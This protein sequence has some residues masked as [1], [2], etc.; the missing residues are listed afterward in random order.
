MSKKYG[1]PGDSKVPTIAGMKQVC[2]LKKGDILFSANSY[3]PIGVKSVEDIGM[4]DVYQVTTDDGRQFVCSAD[5]PIPAGIKTI[6]GIVPDIHCTAKDLLKKYKHT[7]KGVESYMYVMPNSDGINYRHIKVD[8]S[9]AV[10]A[11]LTQNVIQSKCL[12]TTRMDPWVV[13]MIADEFGLSYK[14]KGNVVVFTNR[15]GFPVKADPIL[16][17][18]GYPNRYKPSERK[19]DERYLRGCRNEVE[20]YLIYAKC[21]AYTWPWEQLGS[22]DINYFYT[23]SEAMAKQYQMGLASLGTKTKVKPVAHGYVVYIDERDDGDLL[24]TSVKKLPNQHR[25]YSIGTY[26]EVSPIFLTEEYFSMFAGN[27]FDK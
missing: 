24:I 3:L 16:K 25:C 2:D 14:V 9:P 21:M 19:I 13:D 12:I 22:N 23:E 27:A 1:I 10:A 6:G 17:G 5:Q 7:F 4:R 26:T 8:M 18:I 11:V 20:A 15:F